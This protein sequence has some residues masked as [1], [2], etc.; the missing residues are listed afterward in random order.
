MEKFNYTKEEILALKPED[1]ELALLTFLKELDNSYEIYFQPNLN[2]DRPDIVVVRKG[3]GV[4]VIEVKNFTSINSFVYN[5]DNH[6][7]SP[8]G[9]VKR[10]KN[11]LYDF[12]INGLAEKKVNDSR[13]FG[14]VKCSLYLHGQTKEEAIAILLQYDE[15]YKKSPGRY[16]IIGNDSLYINEFQKIL[17]K[18][19][20]LFSDELYKEFK[21]ALKPSITDKEQANKPLYSNTQ[22]NL[23]N[24]LEPKQQKIKGQ[25]GSG[26]T[27]VLAQRAVN[28]HKRTGGNILVLTF[29]ITLK[30]YILDKISAVK[31][32]LSRKNFPGILNYHLFFNI[33]ANNYGLKIS[34]SDDFEDY[35]DIDYFE[36]VKNKINKYDAIFIDEIQ[37][38]KT[39][40]IKIIKK[41]FLADN[42]EFVIFGDGKQNI[43]ERIDID[44]DS[45]ISPSTTIPGRWNEQLKENYRSFGEI[46]ELSIEFRNTFF[47]DSKTMQVQELKLQ[48]KPQKN[49]PVFVKYYN[50]DLEKQTSNIASFI[51]KFCREKNIQEK[52]LCIISSKIETVREID[53]LYRENNIGKNSLTTF[54]ELET[55]NNLKHDK[56][57][58]LKL[59]KIQRSKKYNFQMNPGCL[60][61][62]T[63]HSF[64]GWESPYIFLIL[65][66]NEEKKNENSNM[67]I[68]TAITRA[69]YGLYIFSLA[70][71]KYDKFF[72]DFTNKQ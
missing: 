27:L 37:D 20:S 3:Y 35:D 52:D 46:N 7:E 23:I 24:R 67:L 60:K 57:R 64:K 71:E 55:Y 13:Y 40:W 42:G 50:F 56:D 59:K 61:L 32:D 68:Y 72:I 29:N 17:C 5:Q 63:I 21:E 34:K 58:E 36:S 38:Y 2:M 10:Y 53:F 45:D 54:E 19:S 70:N 47:A 51:P 30:N 62:S 48:E 31:G 11:N 12:H 9:Q 49:R 15:E 41:Y 28:A 1:G 69:R 22:K 65:N 66:K 16:T 14:I 18:K 43:Y 26:K 33:E 6:K 8:A 25:A 44:A 4:I 39:E